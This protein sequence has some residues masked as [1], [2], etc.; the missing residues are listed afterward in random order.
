M[1]LC[2]WESGEDLGEVVGEKIIFKIYCIE[3]SIFNEE[4]KTS[5]GLTLPDN[6]IYL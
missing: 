3:K 6:I 5:L 4:E 1:D 2:K